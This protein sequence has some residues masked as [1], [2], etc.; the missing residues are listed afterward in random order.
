MQ[1]EAEGKKNIS[2]DL[3]VAVEFLR[4]PKTDCSECSRRKFYQKGYQDGLNA[5]KWIPIEERLPK[6]CEMVLVCL[7]QGNVLVGHHT[8][9]CGWYSQLGCFIYSNVI[10]YYS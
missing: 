4:Q 7:E 2:E 10:I 6:D 5:D 9:I 3:W 8:G 1:F